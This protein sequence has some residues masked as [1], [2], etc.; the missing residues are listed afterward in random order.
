M[1]RKQRNPRRAADPIYVDDVPPMSTV[2]SELRSENTR[3]RK[4]IEL[5]GRVDRR[6]AQIVLVV[7][8]TI[9]R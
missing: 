1:R 2:L 5:L 8:S 9:E 7:D 6:N 3:L 4:T